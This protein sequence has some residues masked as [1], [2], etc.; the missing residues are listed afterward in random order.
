MITLTI[1]LACAAPLQEPGQVQPNGG[2][3]TAAGEAPR[4]WVP[5]NNV[6]LIVNEECVTS[7]DIQREVYFVARRNQIP[8]DDLQ[9]MKRVQVGVFSQLA[10]SMLEQQAGQD[11]GFSPEQVERIADD[12]MEREK[13]RAGSISLLAEDLARREKDSLTLRTETKSYIYGRL[14]RDAATGKGPSPGGRPSVDHYVRPGR[15]YFEHRNQ[16]LLQVENRKV[17]FTQLIVAEPEGLEPSRNLIEEL[18]Q[19]IV[20]GDDMGDLAERYGRANK[21][22]RGQSDFLQVSRLKEPFRSFLT[23][24]EI[25]DL[26]EIHPF[27]HEGEVIGYIVIRVDDVQQPELPEFSDRRNQQAFEKKVGESLEQQLILE[28]LETLAEAAYV[29]PPGAL[30][31]GPPQPPP[32]PQERASKKPGEDE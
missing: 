20:D 8:N 19:R 14:Y 21:G 10:S 30:T 28:G 11:L 7:M 24:A 6:A 26:S 27:E 18:R 32:T 15:L 4:K 2:N 22:T 29:W 13:E 5:L 23:H 16:Q 31:G 25:G 9:G 12:Q 1:L 3:E 17:Q